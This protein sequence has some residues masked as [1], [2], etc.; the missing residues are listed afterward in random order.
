[1]TPDLKALRTAYIAV[2]AVIMLGAIVAA[3]LHN[4]YVAAGLIILDSIIIFLGSMF[5]TRRLAEQEI[6]KLKKD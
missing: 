3:F 6:K 1:M 5:I 2:A 4:V